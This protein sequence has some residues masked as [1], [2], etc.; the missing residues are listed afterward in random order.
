[1]FI[2]GK[3]VNLFASSGGSLLSLTDRTGTNTGSL[4]G[5]SMT[6]I[7]TI[8]AGDG[9]IAFRGLVVLPAATGPISISPEPASLALLGLGLLPV[10]LGALRRRRRAVAASQ[11]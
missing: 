6:S 9:N 4:T 5:T 10:G 2:T 8:T 3:T 7:K 1:M 11:A